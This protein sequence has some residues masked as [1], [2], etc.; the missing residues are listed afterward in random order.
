MTYLHLSFFLY[1]LLVMLC[2]MIGIAA[3]L[4]PVGKYK[5]SYR[6]R[7]QN[8]PVSISLFFVACNF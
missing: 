8:I 5:C 6:Y 1:L 2:D 3:G 4:Q 7:H